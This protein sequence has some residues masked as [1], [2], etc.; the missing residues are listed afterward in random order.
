[1]DSD[2]QKQEDELGK[3]LSFTVDTDIYPISS[4][5]KACYW[6][7]DLAYIF[8]KK[9][10]TTRIEIIFRS[11]KESF[12]PLL[13]SKAQ[14]FMNRV[15]DENVRSLV[16]QKTEVFQDIIVKKAFSEALSQV[17]KKVLQKWEDY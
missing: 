5:M 12:E 1:M 11:K 9:L 16:N 4:L 2:F 10:D 17:D 14:E 15:L 13:L 7:T 8:L 6:Y 3:Y